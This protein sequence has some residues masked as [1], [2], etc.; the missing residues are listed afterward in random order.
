MASSVIDLLLV[1]LDEFFCRNFADGTLG[2]RFF[3]LMHVSADQ[4]SPF[5]MAYP[6]I[7][8]VIVETVL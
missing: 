3:S 8:S 6:P 4:T 7:L 1:F 5:H 2:R